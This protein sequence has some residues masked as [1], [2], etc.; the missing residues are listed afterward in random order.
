LTCPRKGDVR[1]RNTEP[2]LDPVL[3]EQAYRVGVFPMAD[4]VSGEI[5][6]YAPDPRAIIEL[7]DFEVPRSLRSLVRRGVYDVRWDTD[8]AGVIRACAER[9]ETW[10]SPASPTRPTHKTRLAL[11]TSKGLRVGGKFD[12][13]NFKSVLVVPPVSKKGSAP[14]LTSGYRLFRW[15]SSL[16]G[17]SCARQAEA[18]SSANTIL[19]FMPE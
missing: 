18:I 6:W 9:S 10:I 5:A 11:D 14:K 1:A 15:A 2:A 4:E 19:R 12:R 16:T 3:V 17:S 13:S 8:F 7:D